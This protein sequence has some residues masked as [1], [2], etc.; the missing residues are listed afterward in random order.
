[1]RLI[2]FDAPSPPSVLQCL[3]APIPEPK[4]DEVLI[5]A[6]AIGVGIPDVLIRAETYSF[7][8]RF[9]P[10]QALRVK[11]LRVAISCRILMQL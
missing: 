9:Q 8:P 10:L 5:R 2:Q 3:D 7:M 6:H 1:M 4:S 11:P